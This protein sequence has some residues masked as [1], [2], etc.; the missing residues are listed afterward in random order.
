MPA[1]SPVRA[2]SNRAK[3]P[4]SNRNRKPSANKSPKT[5][6]S[7]SNS[8]KSPKKSLNQNQ[9]KKS[10][11]SRSRSPSPSNKMSVSSKNSKKKSDTTKSAD[12]DPA[13]DNFNFRLRLICG[14]ILGVIVVFAWIKLRHLMSFRVLQEGK[15]TVDSYINVAPTRSG[16]TYALIMGTIIGLTLPGATFLSMCGGV[17]FPQPYAAIWTYIGYVGGASCSYTLVRFILGDGIKSWLVGRSGMFAKFEEGFRKNRN[18][19]ETVTF[20]I[21]VR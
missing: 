14:S 13:P 11:P 7:G 5:K 21:F 1:K 9:K 17:F 12:S 18:W 15:A 4:A 16:L 10:S 3:S 2:S 8:G 20:L 6:R 19:V